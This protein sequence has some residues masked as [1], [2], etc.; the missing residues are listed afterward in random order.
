M[1]TTSITAYNNPGRANAYHQKKGFDPARKERMLGV[2]LRL[3][4]ELS[5]KGGWLLE[6]GAGTGDFTK[7]IIS[8]NHFSKLFVTDG[9]EAMLTINQR[10]NAAS[11]H[12][13]SLLDFSQS[14]WSN[15]Y[16]E[17]VDAVA[18]SMAIHHLEHK[19]LLFEQV[20]EVLKPGGAF[21]FTDHVAGSSDVTQ[22]LINLER[23]RVK[24]GSSANAKE[25]EQFILGD[26][27]AQAKEGN[28][29]ESVEAYVQMLKDAGF[30]DVDC[31]WREFWLAV[32]VAKKPV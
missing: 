11:N 32:F 12:A 31:L 24:L 26:E 8:L 2:A 7:R 20:F 21:A 1:S 6:L 4:Q 19:Q 23:A 29:C 30:V 27:A 22:H 16:P 13:F 25:L 5:L 15:D 10:E 18:S 9:A 14:A 17:R 28:Y 3:L